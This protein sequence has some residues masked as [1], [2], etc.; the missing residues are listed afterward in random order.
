MNIL[1]TL[2]QVLIII[3]QEVAKL[4]NSKELFDKRKDLMEKLEM[5]ND[6]AQIWLTVR[7]AV[8]QSVSQQVLKNNAHM[9]SFSVYKG[10]SELEVKSLIDYFSNKLSEK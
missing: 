1:L 2:D 7:Q 8:V 10:V 5:K 6:D 4:W 3:E 9:I